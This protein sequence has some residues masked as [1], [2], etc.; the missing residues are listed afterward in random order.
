MEKIKIGIIGGAGY[1][2]GELLRILVN[3]PRVEIGF[4]QSTSHSG[5]PVTHVHNDLVGETG[6]IFTGEPRYEEA[7]LL[8]LCQGHGKSRLFLERTPLPAGTRLID[9]S[10]DYRIAGEGHRFGYG[11]P[12]LQRETVRG[13]SQV[14]NPGCF[15]TGIQLGLLPLAAAGL[16]EGDIHVQAITGSTG[17]GQQPTE[18]TH[19][20]YREGNLSAYKI[21]EHQH[22]AEIL[23]SLL[24]LQPQFSSG[25][26]F[27]PIRGNHTRGIFVSMVTR[28]SGAGEDARELYEEYYREHPFTVVTDI[29]PSLK[30][31]VNTN[32]ALVYTEKHGNQ[33]VIITVSD[34]LL[35]GAS[36]QAIQNMNLMAG[37]EETC[38]LQLKPSAF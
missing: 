37:F 1:T 23:Q 18:T 27:I 19:F 11:L 30:Q 13:A 22:Q 26:H 21:F 14:A 38:G 7:E 2:A 34:N 32:K 15:A 20:S 12:E 3:H 28:F 6:L 16:L 24:Q 4:V 5:Q 29:N 8:F 33:L 36:G 31:V 25:F 35:K 17:A 10:A 9:L